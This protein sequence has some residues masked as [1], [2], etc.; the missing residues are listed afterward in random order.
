MHLKRYR[1]AT[2]QEALALARRDMGP[3]ALVL[4]TNLVPASGPR[5]WLGRRVVEITAATD[6]LE[7]GV[8]GVSGVSAIRSER[9]LFRQSWASLSGAEGARRREALFA[10]LRTTGLDPATATQVVDALPRHLRKDVPLALLRRAM[11]EALGAVAGASDGFA[12]F[13]V[14]VGP[15][16]AGKTTTVAKIAARERARNG[17]RL[18]LV[19]ADGFRVGAVEQLRLY[20]EIIGS[21]FVVARTPDELDE[22]LNDQS[23]YA[24]VDTAGRSPSDPEARAL[25]ERLA[26]RP[27]VRTHL[28]VP[29]AAATSAV[30]RALDG[31]QVA[32]P[33][34]VVLTKVDE[35]EGIAPLVGLL[36]QRQLRVSFVGT[37]QR[38]PE[39]LE[40]GTATVLAGHALAQASPTAGSLA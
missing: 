16:G 2:V 17:R 29:A 33:S 9:P 11:A 6:R 24:L 1:G 28:V 32:A 5:G 25:I 14:F 36:R 27:G 26:G 21:A 37:G 4:S 3:S 38:V 39:D 34:R 10:Q 8:Q 22:V 7:S 15:P 13:E 40:P 23:G 18:T 35:A 30:E 19:A 12:P 20:A 31:Y